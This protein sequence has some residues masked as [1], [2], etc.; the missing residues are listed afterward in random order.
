[1]AME[2]YLTG[3][4]E[5]VFEGRFGP[6]I[7]ERLSDT[8]GRPCRD[9]GL[10]TNGDCEHIANLVFGVLGRIRMKPDP[11]S[12]DADIK[13]HRVL[14]F[15]RG[16]IFLVLERRGR[17]DCPA[18]TVSTRLKRQTCELRKMYLHKAYRGK[19]LGQVVAR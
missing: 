7:K 4:V 18:P 8:S 12:T 16:G 15:W 19:G 5:R 9:C 10:R 14:V 3:P 11:A 13:G 2:M 17:L 6:D 1:M